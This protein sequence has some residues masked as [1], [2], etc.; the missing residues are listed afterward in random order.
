MAPG[1]HRRPERLAS[2]T[3]LDPGGLEKAGLRF[4]AWAFVSLFASF[5]P[6]ALRPRLASWL[7]QPVIAVPELRTWVHAHGSCS[8]ARV[9][10]GEESRFVIRPYHNDDTAVP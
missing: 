6:R 2:L 4:F 1:G 9:T 8:L 7:E 10:S 3:A 5:A